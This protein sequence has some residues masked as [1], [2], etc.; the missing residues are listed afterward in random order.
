MK[1][2][3]KI[4]E[5]KEEQTVEYEVVY[6]SKL[7][8]K[9]FNSIDELKQAEEAFKLEEQ[10]KEEARLA[11]K[12]EAVV[13]E[14]AINTYEATK[15]ECNLTIQEAYEAY[16]QVVSEANRKLVEAEKIADE[17]LTA[18]LNAHPGER[19]HYSYES[20]DGKVKREYNYLN[21]RYTFADQFNELQKIFTNFWKF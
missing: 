17:K 10:K 5:V 4:N 11:K 1:T 6:K 7:L 19:F 18:W 13:V 2:K 14:Q 9:E 8:N 20:P 15:A 3:E 12:A 16:K 21:N